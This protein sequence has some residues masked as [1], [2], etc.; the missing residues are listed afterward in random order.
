[1]EGIQVARY[2]EHTKHLTKLC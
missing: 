1:M 2:D